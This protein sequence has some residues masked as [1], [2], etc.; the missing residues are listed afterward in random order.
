MNKEKLNCLYKN[1]ISLQPILSDIFS[2][3][4]LGI[5][6]DKSNTILTQEEFNK[7]FEEEILSKIDKSKTVFPEKNNFSHITLC[8]S[9]NN[10]VFDYDTDSKNS[11]FR[12][13]YE[14]VCIVFM[15]K[16][17]LHTLEIVEFHQYMYSLIESHFNLRDI[18]LTPIFSYIYCN[19]NR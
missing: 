13:H 11:H 5:S 3:E 19:C 18:K 4:E 16:F 15:N 17:N 10:W 12:Y 2:K 9:N 14:R 1:N 7:F 6:S 8:D